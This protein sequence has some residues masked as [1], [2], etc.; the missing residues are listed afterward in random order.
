MYAQDLDQFCVHTLQEFN[1]RTNH[2]QLPKQNTVANNHH[3]NKEGEAECQVTANLEAMKNS[4]PQ[5]SSQSGSVWRTGHTP[6]YLKSR[7]GDAETP[8]RLF[9]F[10]TRFRL[11]GP[12]LEPVIR[13]NS[14]SNDAAASG[15]LVWPSKTERTA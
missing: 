1:L 5:P 11:G 14:C 4:L 15:A 12:S 8:P 10:G 6:I 13:T 9:S 2:A 3:Q 7:C